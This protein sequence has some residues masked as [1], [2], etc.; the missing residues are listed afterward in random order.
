METVDSNT[1][2][3]A[4]SATMSD[5]ALNIMDDHLA[6]LTIKQQIFVREFVMNSG[7]GTR[8]AEAAGYS[9]SSEN[10]LACQAH[11]NIRKPHIAEAIAEEFSFQCRTLF[12][13]RNKYLWELTRLFKEALSDKAFPAALS[14]LKEI[15]VF[16]GYSDGDESGGTITIHLTSPAAA[17]KDPSTVQQPAIEHDNG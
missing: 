13:S 12:W 6:G 4:K 2:R 5:A 17:S 10:S 7:N 1:G 8:A 15:G 9:A 16:Q 3:R 11:D 14:A